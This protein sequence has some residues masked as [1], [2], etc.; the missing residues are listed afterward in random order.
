[1]TYWG[2]K[3]YS[4]ENYFIATFGMYQYQ[5][6]AIDTTLVYKFNYWCIV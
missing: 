6:K 2:I 1:M 3:M 5:L 4:K